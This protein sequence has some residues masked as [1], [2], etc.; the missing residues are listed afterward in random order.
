MQELSTTELVSR[1]NAMVNDR[2]IRDNAG[3]VEARTSTNPTLR[4]MAE[5][6]AGALGDTYRLPFQ[7]NQ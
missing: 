5:A 2:I 4:A 1:V 6:P 7:T 3:V